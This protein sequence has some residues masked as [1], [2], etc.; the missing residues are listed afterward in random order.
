MR[1]RDAGVDVDK[2]K[3]FTIIE[4]VVVVAVFAILAAFAVPSFQNLTEKN[5]L[6]AE[7][8]RI[9]SALSYARSEAVRR[10]GGV[11]ITAA[12]GGFLNGWCVHLGVSCQGADIL[13]QFEPGDVAYSSA[14]SNVTFNGRGEMA[15]ANFEIGIEPLNCKAGDVDRGRVIAV[16]PSG[17]ASIQT[18]DCGT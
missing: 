7:A 12:N 6:S 1:Y 2:E 16:A 13:R 18:E 10:G 17:R 14:Q 9:F 5:R 3:G 15:S 11:S 8:N 4:L